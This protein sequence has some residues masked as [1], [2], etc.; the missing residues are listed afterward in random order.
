MDFKHII[1]LAIS[2]LIFIYLFT[3]RHKVRV[4]VTKK[5]EDGKIEKFYQYMP[6]NDY[7]NYYNTH[8]NF[9]FWNMQLG[10]K[11]NMSYDLRGDVPIGGLSW[12]PF[13]MAST[14][15]IRNKPLY[16]VS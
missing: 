15:P 6:Y 14:I 16:L 12:I 11:S 7:M 13:N 8:T 2:I 5:H 4:L 3:N 9:P 1:V 10:N